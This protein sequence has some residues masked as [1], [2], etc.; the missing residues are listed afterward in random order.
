MWMRLAVFAA[1]AQGLYEAAF[2]AGSI[3]NKSLLV[4]VSLGMLAA[5]ADPIRYWPAVLA[6][7]VSRLAPP[8]VSAMTS[9]AR[10]LSTTFAD[11]I[12]WAPLSFVL[13]AAYLLRV[14]RVRSCSREVPGVALRARTDR[15]TTIGQLSCTAPVLLI[16]LRHAGC[17]FCREALADIAAARKGIEASGTTIVLAHMSEPDSG[18][19]VFRK[20][21]L[22][23]LHQISDPCRALYRAFGLQRGGLW[24]L[25]GPKVWVRGLKAGIIRRHGIGRPMGDGFQMPGV[26]LIFHG[27]VLR[28]YRHQSA[29]DRPDYVRFAT[30]DAFSRMVS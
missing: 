7:L 17:T 29:A 21:G 12:W 3:E 11:A 30:E 22:D 4:A 5:S 19:E 16:F 6:G 27:Q 15:G 23:D 1:G 2:T 28:T 10:P 20:Y 24:K 14:D 18:R 25:F 8:V 9:S 26:F 13:Y